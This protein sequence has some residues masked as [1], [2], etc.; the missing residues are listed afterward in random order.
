MKTTKNEKKAGRGRPRKGSL[1]QTKA[2]WSA[3]IIIQVDGVEIRKGVD[4]KTTNKSAARIKMRRLTESSSVEDL[5]V[6]ASREETFREAA[7]RIV[8]RQQEEGMRTAHERLRR[9]ER[10]AYPEL[11]DLACSAISTGMLREVLVAAAKVL[12]KESVDHLRVDMST[13][14]GALWSDDL[15]E[16]NPLEARKLKLPANLRKDGRTR[17]TLTDDEFDRLITFTMSQDSLSTLGLMCLASRCFGGMRTSDLHAWN[18]A[19]VDTEKWRSA[20]VYRPK[21]ERNPDGTPSNESELTSIE[22]PDVLLA[23]LQAYWANQGHPT[24][25]PVFPIVAGEHAG[26]AQGKRSHVRELR[27]A[28][29]RAGIH[30]PLDGYDR[31]MEGL[32]KASAVLAAFR[33]EPGKGSVSEARRAATAAEAEAKK[34]CALQ[35]DT[36]KFRRVDFHSFRR[37]Y[38]TSAYKNSGLSQPEIMELSGH[39]DVRTSVKY[40][41]RKEDAAIGQ[42]AAMLPTLTARTTVAPVPPWFVAKF[43]LPEVANC[44]DTALYTG[45]P[46]E[47]RS[48]VIGARV[49]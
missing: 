27:K 41:N 19:H 13:V 12:Q 28:L 42:P 3:R 9:L 4:L 21:T 25:G 22:I 37:S 14:F 2:G 17:L 29:W 26:E 34:Y 10:Y 39:R 23:P 1:Y 44:L 48:R 38:V 5:E 36:T 40:F 15:I 47:A 11:G 18:W 24:S 6:A 20:K 32:A 16:K 35:T 7:E 49:R 8:A 33:A 30:R 45:E 31:A 43:T 46:D